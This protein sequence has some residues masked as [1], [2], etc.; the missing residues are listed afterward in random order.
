M[1]HYFLSFYIVVSKCEEWKVEALLWPAQAT[2]NITMPLQQRWAD[3]HILR[4]GSSLKFL[5]LSPS[6]TIVQKV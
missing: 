4:S 6:P 2:L 3:C 5:K 1:T